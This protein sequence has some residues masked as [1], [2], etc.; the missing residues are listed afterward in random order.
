MPR[1]MLVIG[2]L[3]ASG[4]A[5]AEPPPSAPSAPALPRT[6]P[7]P[8]NSPAAPGT[9]PA[10]RLSLQLAGQHDFAADLGGG[11]ESTVSRVGSELGLS[12]PAGEGRPNFGLVWE[13]SFYDFDAPAV[14]SGGAEPWDET[15]EL[16]LRGSYLGRID[17]HWGY[18]VGAG[19][20]SAGEE[21]AEFSDT[22]TFGGFAAATYSLS[23][24][25]TFSLG[26]L[27]RE[28]LEDDVLVVPI[29][30]VEWKIDDQ[31]RL[32]SGVR[33]A[34][35]FLLYSPDEAWTLSLGGQYRSREYRLD[36]EGFAPEGVGRDRRIPVE[37]G[38]EYRPGRRVSISGFVG[39][40]VWQEY[41]ID[42]RSGQSLGEDDSDPSPFLGAAIKL[43]F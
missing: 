17:D 38:V 11:G 13:S 9:P 6:D 29:P 24:D 40:N 15:F 21:G 33:P 14:L 1:P 28:R 30:G 19:V 20:N 31:W 5:I 41:E 43:S 23:E 37:F 39:V 35:L 32:S 4:S 42:S 12:I 26:I 2:L 8:A 22:V 18:V 10:W 34:G 3:A 27:V 36:D 7:P 16:E 25:L